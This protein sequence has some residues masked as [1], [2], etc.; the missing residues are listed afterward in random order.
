MDHPLSLY[1]FEIHPL[2]EDVVMTTY[3]VKDDT[4]MQITLRSSIW[5]RIDGRWQ[6]FFHQGTPT[7]SNA[8][9]R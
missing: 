5:K 6:M 8:L 9:N 2:A 7:N 1:Q 3:R 4:R